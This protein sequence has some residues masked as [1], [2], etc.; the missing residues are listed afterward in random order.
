[1]FTI[2][3]VVSLNVNKFD[4]LCYKM[5]RTFFT[6]F[7]VVEMLKNIDFQGSYGIYSKTCIREIMMLKTCVCGVWACLKCVCVCVC[8]IMV[9][10][11]GIAYRY[12]PA[13]S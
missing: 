9:I 5:N 12:C 2:S 10:V 4:V 7:L 3:H 1:M 13:S 8:V 11:N 6:V